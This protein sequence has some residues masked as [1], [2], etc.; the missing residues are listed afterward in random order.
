MEVIAVWIP[1]NRFL[2]QRQSGSINSWMCQ[3][4][5]F[6]ELCNILVQKDLLQASTDLK[7]TCSK[8]RNINMWAFLS[9]SFLQPSLSFPPPHHPTC[10]HV[11]FL[12]VCIEP[13]S[14]DCGPAHVHRP[15]RLLQPQLPW[16]LW[17][18][19]EPCGGPKV[20]EHVGDE[21]ARCRRGGTA[22]LLCTS[23]GNL[24]MMH[25]WY[26]YVDLSIYM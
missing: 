25:K 24:L 21:C 26:M 8:N 11:V 22:R 23:W 20:P 2:G 3:S 15:A 17:L 19:H 5:N 9:P 16:P 13:C 1:N 12:P 18:L 14:W 4:L 6:I 10:L 7:H